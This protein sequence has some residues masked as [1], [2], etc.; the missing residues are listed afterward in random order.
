MPGVRLRSVAGDGGVVHLHGAPLGLRSLPALVGVHLVLR[1]RLPTPAPLPPE[2]L[3]ARAVLVGA[4]AV[5]GGD[6]EVPAEHTA[7]CG[8]DDDGPPAPDPLPRLAG[9]LVPGEQVPDVV[10]LLHCR[11]ARRLSGLG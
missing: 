11:T 10:C 1:R 7:L 8:A 5:L 4:V 2:Q 9:R 3:E 6:G